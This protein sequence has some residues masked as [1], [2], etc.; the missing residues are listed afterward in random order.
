[1]ISAMD[2]TL[3]VSEVFPSQISDPKSYYEGAD[4]PNRIICSNVIV[5]ERLSWKSLQQPHVGNRM[6]HR[7]VL[8]RVLRSAGVVSVDGQN[9]Q[10]DVGDALLVTPY[11]FHHYIEIESDTL[12]WLFITFE[13]EQGQPAL[14]DL[15]YRRLRPDLLTHQLWGEVAHLWSSDTAASR[16]ELIPTLDRLLARLHATTLRLPQ[17]ETV[18]ATTGNGWIAQVETLIIRSVREGWTFEEVAQRAGFSERHLRERFEKQMGLSL[19][20][21][22]SN[23]QFHTAI[24]LMRDA[25]CSLADVA[26]LSGFNSQSVFTRFIRRMA[27]CTPRELCRQVREGRYEQSSE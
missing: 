19:R 10:L 24:S 26:E 23:Y 3:Q 16:L 8:M 7:Y 2:R 21:Y 11:Q 12:R 17:V 27:G 5:F 15:S 25:K 22:R 6:H 9:Y 20:D 13:L 18:G 1:M 14:A 4:Q